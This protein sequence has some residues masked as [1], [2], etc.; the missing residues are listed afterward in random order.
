MPILYY[1]VLYVDFFKLLTIYFKND[2][3]LNF[4]NNFDNYVIIVTTSMH[5]R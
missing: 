1:I 3:S 5:A 4:A 2:I